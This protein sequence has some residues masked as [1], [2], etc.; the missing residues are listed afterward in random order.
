MKRAKLWTYNG[1]SKTM[2]DWADCVGISTISLRMRLRN[3]WDFGK[4]VTTRN[5]NNRYEYNGNLYTL[6]EI[7]DLNGTMTLGG[8]STRLR[9]GM[10]VADAI[11]TP[12]GA[13]APL[14]G[15][16]PKFKCDFNCFQCPYPDCYK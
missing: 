15:S 10:S 7:T 6:S 1:V 9:K 3:G 12:K 13:D 5:M 4:A 11:E 16:K 14:R 8:M 2:S